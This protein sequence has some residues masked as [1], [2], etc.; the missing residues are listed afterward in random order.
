MAVSL[1]HTIV[2]AT[3]KRASA[4]FLRRILGLLEPTPWGPFLVVPVG[5][6]VSLD[7]MDAHDFEE[8]HYAFLVDETEFDPI[9]E[10]I[11]TSGAAYYADPFRHRP[12]EINYLYGGRGVY[13]DDPDHHFMEVI[14]QPY[15]ETPEG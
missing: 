1:N 5:N 2:P 10:R 3:D 14:T 8:H 9:F 11:R 12:D 6:G 13:F 4:D 15:G 7:F